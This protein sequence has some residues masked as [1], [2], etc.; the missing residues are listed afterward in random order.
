[1][2]LSWQHLLI[3]LLIVLLVFGGKKLRN[4]GSDLGA[5]V[6]GFKKAMNEDEEEK[7]TRAAL[8]HSGEPDADFDAEKKQARAPR[9]KD[10]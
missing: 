7:P 10:A 6:R 3:V 4:V 1:M 8:P 2:G 5:A 9:D